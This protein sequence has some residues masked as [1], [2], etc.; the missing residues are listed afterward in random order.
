MKF[1]TV[2]STVVDSTI[3]KAWPEL[4]RKAYETKDFIPGL[5]DLIIHEKNED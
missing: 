2:T 5:T 3:E 1:H 4:W